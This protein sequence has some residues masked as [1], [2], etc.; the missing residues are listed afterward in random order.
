MARSNLSLVAVGDL[1]PTRRL[2]RDGAPVNREFAKTVDRLH[3]DSQSTGDGSAK[4]GPG[5]SPKEAVGLEHAEHALI[6]L[7]DI[8]GRRTLVTHA[9]SNARRA[10]STGR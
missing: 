9:L 7:S 1:V 3:S 6:A 8:Q 5:R 10:R 4:C 2:W